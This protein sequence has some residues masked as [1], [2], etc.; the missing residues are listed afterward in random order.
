MLLFYEEESYTNGLYLGQTIK[1]KS[2]VLTP[3]IRNAQ[4]VQCGRQKKK[5]IDADCS[6]TII[7]WVEEGL[8][9]YKM[10]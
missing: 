5:N 8:S 6:N 3:V 1:N 9:E 4:K 2:I 10:V 7:N